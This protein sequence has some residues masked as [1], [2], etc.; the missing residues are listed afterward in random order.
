MSDNPYASPIHQQD[1]QS[2]LPSF[3]LHATVQ[4]DEEIYARW[5]GLAARPV[6]SMTLRAAAAVVG[7]AAC[8]VGGVLVRVGASSPDGSLRIVGGVAAIFLLPGI[9]LLAWSVYAVQLSRWEMQQ[10][11]NKQGI[12][13]QPLQI[14]LRPDHLEIKSISGTQIVAWTSYVS[15][16]RADGVLGL[17]RADGNVDLLPTMQL[18]REFTDA[19]EFLARKGMAK[20]SPN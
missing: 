14:T 9:A 16:R 3:P 20:S 5:F 13:S 15:T 12:E 11:L 4:L 7:L 6:F 17:E 10:S 2:E 8:I 18:S 1:K 19:V